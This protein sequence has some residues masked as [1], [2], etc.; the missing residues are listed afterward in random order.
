MK[1]NHSNGQVLSEQEM[2][3]VKGGE[4]Y[5]IAGTPDAFYCESCG[6][7]IYEFGY[8]AFTGTYVAVCDLCGCSKEV[9]VEE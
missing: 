7:L 2:K 9:K 8:N 4:W 6:N 5:V 1:K 3:E